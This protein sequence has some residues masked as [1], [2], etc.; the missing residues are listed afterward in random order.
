MLRF[1]AFVTEKDWDNVVVYS[2]RTTAC[3]D[4][5]RTLLAT[6]HGDA[7]APDSAA[8]RA[9]ALSRIYAAETG[10]LRVIFQS[11]DDTVA[12][13][14]AAEWWMTQADGTG[15]S[16]CQ[17]CV[18]GK[19]AVASESTVCMDCVEGKYSSQSG[20]T[21]CLP[22]GSLQI[23]GVYPTDSRYGATA[24]YSCPPSQ[25]YTSWNTTVKTTAP[26]TSTT[27]VAATRSSSGTTPWPTTSSTTTPAPTTS[28]TVAPTT[29]PPAALSICLDACV[30][31]AFVRVMSVQHFERPDGKYFHTFEDHISWAQ[32]VYSNMYLNVTQARTGRMG[33]VILFKGSAGSDI[34]DVYGRWELDAN[35]GDWIRGDLLWNNPKC[36]AS[37]GEAIQANPGGVPWSLAYST[38]P[39]PT[40]STT[41]SPLTTSS[42]SSTTTALLTSSS[43]STTTTTPT[44]TTSS[45]STPSPTTS[46]STTAA[47]TTS[48]TS[49]PAPTTS[50]TSPALAST[51]GP[52]T[53]PP[54]CQDLTVVDAAGKFSAWMDGDGD[55]CDDYALNLNWCAYAPSYS[56]YGYDA[57]QACCACGGGERRTSSTTAP[58]SSATASS[59]TAAPTTSSSTTVPPTTTSSSSTTFPS[60]TSTS[61]TLSPTTSSSSTTTPMPSSS[62]TTSASPDTTTTTPSP[63]FGVEYGCAACP[64]CAH[65]EY[66][67]D[68]GPVVPPNIYPTEGQCRECPQY[69]TSVAENSASIHGCYCLPGATNFTKPQSPTAASLQP[70]GHYLPC[71]P[72]D[73]GKYRPGRPSFNC[74]GDRCPCAAMEKEAEQGIIRINSTQY[75]NHQTCTIVLHGGSGITLRVKSVNTE[76]AYDFLDIVGCSSPACPLP[77]ALAEY[78]GQHSFLESAVSAQSTFF[79]PNYLK[80]V[81]R[82]DGSVVGEGFEA[83]LQV[84]DPDAC[85]SCPPNANTSTP[86]SDSV[87]QC[88]CPKEYPGPDGGPCLL[89][90]ECKCHP[91]C[92][93]CKC[94]E[95]C[96]E[97]RCNPGEELG[98]VRVNVGPGSPYQAAELT[99]GCPRLSRGFCD[100][101]TFKAFAGSFNDGSQGPED[102]RDNVRYRAYSTCRWI[103]APPGVPNIRLFLHGGTNILMSDV[104]QINECDDITCSTKRALGVFQNGIIPYADGTISCEATGGGSDVCHASNVNPVL[105]VDKAEYTSSTGFMEVLFKSESLITRYSTGFTASWQSGQLMCH[106]CAAGK[107]RAEGADTSLVHAHYFLEKAL[108]PII[109]PKGGAGPALENDQCTS[110]PLNTNSLPGSSKLSHCLCVPGFVY[111]ADAGSGEPGCAPCVAVGQILSTLERPCTSFPVSTPFICDPC[112]QPWS[113]GRARSERWSTAKHPASIAN[114]TRFLPAPAQRR[115]RHVLHIQ[116][117]RLAAPNVFAAQAMCSMPLAPAR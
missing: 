4:T 55:S 16:A 94:D 30:G 75:N 97:C 23:D 83:E 68:C 114:E 91:S 56:R 49:T 111:S 51:Q 84:H 3:S 89:C 85:T 92:A 54:A 115:A 45:S 103:I 95:I 82:T 52:G 117:R 7:R 99:E 86:G 1:N 25:Y 81:F 113:L 18:P 33:L 17:D 48:T 66:R 74:S 105:L 77:T 61:S 101:R 6:L 40:T 76:E 62:T 35:D 69:S 73:F 71:R 72:C 57:R 47:P 104:L 112:V 65:G 14:W 41:T 110:C 98:F 2:C 26:A 38:T 93:R 21:S 29:T 87:Y 90:K 63:D 70:L 15:A 37:C 80:M 43:S 36:A 34:G 20:R 109:I 5:D 44:P 9:G 39:C 78:T 28:S 96:S 42:S 108:L 107:Y 22:C 58:A 19:Y 59:T 46:S 88:K 12:A 11:D 8:A 64:G 24:C 53:T 79:W 31:C 32:F 106:K 102:I 10:I 60:S 116:R 50:S 13:G 27:S 100:C 67:A